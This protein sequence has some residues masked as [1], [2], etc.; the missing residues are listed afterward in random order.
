MK[1]DDLKDPGRA[2]LLLENAEPMPLPDDVPE[3]GPPLVRFRTAA[4]LAAE[5]PALVRWVIWPLVAAGTIT[6]LSGAAKLAGKTTLVMRA[7]A[8]MVLGERWLDHPTI[9]GPVVYLT[10]EP[11][12]SFRLALDRAGLTECKDLHVLSRHCSLATWEGA[13]EAARAKAKEVGAV[14]LVVDT[15]AEW[16]DL[17]SDAENN[18]GDAKR[19]IA[20][21]KRAAAEGLAVLVIAH[22]RKSGG[23]VGQS[24]RGSSALPGAVETIICVHS[25]ENRTERVLEM[26]GRLDMPS[27]LVL[28]RLPDGSYLCKGSKDSV[29]HEQRHLDARSVEERLVA[30]VPVGREQTLLR[31]DV[32]A[33]RPEGISQ[34]RWIEAVDRAEHSGQL[35]HKGI[36]KRNNHFRYWRPGADEHGDAFPTLELESLASPPGNP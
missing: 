24:I 8:A 20:P 35:S 17:G 9:R 1:L 16:T 10:E 19:V 26:R 31:D 30:M 15:Y 12:A 32:L 25:G 33:L 29:A 18:A 6:L 11:D 27:S 5:T 28:D 3:E 22:D 21:L 36:G 14:L 2:L 13:V 4:E 34:R 7:I 23:D